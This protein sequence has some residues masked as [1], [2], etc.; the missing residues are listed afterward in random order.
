MRTL[1]RVLAVGFGAV[2]LL[3][4]LAAAIG[5]SNAR[6]TARSAAGLVADQL[7]ITRLLDEMEREQEVLNNAFYRLS[8]TPEKVD[9]ERMLA[10]LDQ[11]DR[12]IEE[13]V[14]KSGSGP[15]RYVWLHLDRAVHEFSS[16]ARRLLHRSNV[17]PAA[18]RDLFLL[19]EQVT[20]EVARLVDLSY[21]R[22]VETE[23]RVNRQTA[24]LAGESAVLV[25][26][27]LMVALACA[28]F[29]VRLAARVFR[30]MEEQA[31]ELSRVSF[32]LLEIQESVA[33]RFAHELHDELGGALTAIKTNLS[34]MLNGSAPDPAR[35]EDC[36]KLV[37]QSISNVRELS[38]L[39]RP[40]ILDDFG[41]DAS[42]RWLL[43]R[44][45]ERTHIK[46]E[47]RSEFAGRLA[48]ELETHLFRIVQEALTNIARH[49]GATEVTI[50]LTAGGGRVR[51]A[52]RDNGRGL[53]PGTRLGMGLSGMRARAKSAGGEMK[54][55]SSPG[56]GV[57]I[58]VWAPMSAPKAA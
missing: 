3:L 55:T 10:D 18:S 50:N 36:N 24:R 5:V 26:G 7:V 21:A 6:S 39:L 25:G 23:Q 15:E 8:R 51:L 47:Y 53:E 28:I 57:A 49:S 35:L 20:G 58:E 56:E 43:E 54:F 44:F 29:T 52:V 42:L 38:Q 13:Q 4:V 22:A 41:L 48:D 17:S 16:E 9:L 12:D 11:T 1:V 27:C 32:R 31:S 45:Q 19:H 2:I 14:H 33:R 40:T 30:K 37:D 34:T 46:V